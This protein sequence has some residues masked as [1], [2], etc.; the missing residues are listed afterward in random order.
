MEFART[1]SEVRPGYDY[2]VSLNGKM[3]CP[4]KRMA[5]LA[6]SDAEIEEA[7]Q[8]IRDQ[9]G[10]VEVRG[11]GEVWFEVGEEPDWS[12]FTESRARE[13]VDEMAPEE[14]TNERV[15]LVSREYLN[16]AEA[17]YRVVVPEHVEWQM[18][19]E[20]DDDEDGDEDETDE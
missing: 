4:I 15:T 13:M 16:D 8:I 20:P 17:E 6:G 10:D 11:I 5:Q 2:W 1:Q 12:G 18:D 9:G 7:A 19:A 14:P 3:W